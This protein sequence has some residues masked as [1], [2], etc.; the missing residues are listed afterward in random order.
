MRPQCCQLLIED[1]C[2]QAGLSLAAHIRDDGKVH[3]SAGPDGKIDDILDSD[4]FVEL[5]SDFD[6][7]VSYLAELIA[8]S[9]PGEPGV[10]ALGR[11]QSFIQKRYG[12]MQEASLR[13]L[14]WEPAEQFLPAR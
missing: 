3:L 9:N 4:R 10:R 5:V 13:R 11:L 14:I 2:A 8:Y 12:A 1:F 7:R 6:R